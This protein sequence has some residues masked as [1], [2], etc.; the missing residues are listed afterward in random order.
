MNPTSA[1][2]S[3]DG[4]WIV[5][6]AGPSTSDGY[7]EVYLVHPEGSELRQVTSSTDDCASLAPIWSPDGTKVLFETE[8]YSGIRVTST[9]L[10]TVNL[11]G[12]GLADVANLNGLTSYGWGPEVAG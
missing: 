2:W 7:S 8:C 1:Q 6:S 5:F 3:P 4:K 10:Q 12:S 9:R 11:D